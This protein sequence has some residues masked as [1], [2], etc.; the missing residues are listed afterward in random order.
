METPQVVLVPRSADSPPQMQSKPWAVRWRIPALLLTPALVSMINFGEAYFEKVRD[1]EVGDLKYEQYRGR[2]EAE[3]RA[4][5]ASAEDA[6]KA[7]YSAIVAEAEAQARAEIEV[8][9]KER[10]TKINQGSAKGSIPISLAD[11]M[12][13]A[14]FGKTTDIV[15]LVH[16]RA[17]LEMGVRSGRYLKVD[18]Q[19]GNFEVQQIGTIHPDAAEWKNRLAGTWSSLGDQLYRLSDTM[20]SDGASEMASFAGNV[21]L[22]SPDAG[23]KSW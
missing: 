2:A 17:E 10:Q 22:F 9:E 20:A 16:E 14:M 12:I 5:I 23:G 18:R 1:F 19:T 4:V 11:G 6:A 3:R 8:G 15:K 13:L 7:S 21:C